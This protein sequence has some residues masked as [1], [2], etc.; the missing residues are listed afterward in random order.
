[1]IKAET[2]NYKMYP[3]DIERIHNIST[4]LKSERRPDNNT[5]TVRY[6]LWFT[7]KELGLSK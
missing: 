3:E 7:E 4:H 1:M 2:K 6:A 5:A